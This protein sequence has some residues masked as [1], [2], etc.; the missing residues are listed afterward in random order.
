[1]S[2]D[3]RHYLTSGDLAM[4][5][6]VLAQT[7]FPRSV[8]ALKAEARSDAARLLIARFQR[9]ETSEVRLRET[10]SEL[11]A[12]DDYGYEAEGY[13][14]AISIAAAGDMT[15]VLPGV[16]YGYGKRIETDK[17]WTIY[18]VFTGIP[19]SIGVS[20]LV[21]LDAKTAIRALRMLNTP[22]FDESNDE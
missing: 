1:M 6:R 5:E 20:D 2:S 10:L 18:H 14:V 9:G 17:S 21:Q 7:N 8:D 4:L 19:A 16:Q 11:S 12:V 22:E 13:D 15:T 3:G